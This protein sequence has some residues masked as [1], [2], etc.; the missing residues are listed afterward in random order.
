MPSSLRELL[1]HEAVRE[2]A[3]VQG[4]LGFMA[5]H[6][7]IEPCTYRIAREAALA[8][9]ASIYAVVQPESRDGLEGHLTSTKYSRAESKLLDAFLNRVRVVVSVH[10]MNRRDM[11]DKIALGGRNRPLARRVGEVLRRAGFDAIDD[12]D[13]MPRY[14]RGA[15][16]DNPVNIPRCEGVQIE[17]GRDLR[18]DPG[19]VAD[20]TEILTGVARTRLADLAH[21]R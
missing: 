21:H 3:A 15:H 5:L 17:I 4:A 7:G 11:N 14:L 20:L 1:R 12:L 19:S 8:T 2:V 10:G 18:R 13:G 9:G 6:G 16:R